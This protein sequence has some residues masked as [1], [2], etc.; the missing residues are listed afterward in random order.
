MSGSGGENFILYVFPP[1]P[2]TPSGS[3]SHAFQ[4]YRLRSRPLA[5]LSVI[6]PSPSWRDGSL[7]LHTDVEDTKGEFRFF[8]ILTKEPQR[9]LHG[10]K[11]YLVPW[12]FVRGEEL[13]FKAFRTSMIIMIEKAGTQDEI[14][15]IYKREVYEDVWLQIIDFGPGLLFRFSYSTL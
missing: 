4:A 2:W 13:D 10:G 15:L 9:F 6:V 7:P 3:R 12:N 11:R 1:I 5:G 14:K 8:H